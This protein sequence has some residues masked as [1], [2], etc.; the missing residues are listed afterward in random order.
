MDADFIIF[1]YYFIKTVSF[2]TERCVN[3]QIFSLD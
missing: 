1:Y 3:V 2:T